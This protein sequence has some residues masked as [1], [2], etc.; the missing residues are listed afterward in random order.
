ML[1]ADEARAA[2]IAAELDRANHERREIER[3][4]LADAEA[5]RRELPGR[6]RPTPPGSCSPARAGIRAWSGSSPRGW[7]S[8]TTAR[9]S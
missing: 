8:A 1:T 6:A 2:E 7:S 5:R 9:W 3:E 4:V